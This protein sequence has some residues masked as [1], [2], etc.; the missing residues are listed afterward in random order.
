MKIEGFTIVD[1]KEILNLDRKSLYVAS[2]EV[3]DLAKA[4]ESSLDDICDGS[5]IAKLPKMLQIGYKSRFEKSAKNISAKIKSNASDKITKESGEIVIVQVARECLCEKFNHIAIPLAELFHSKESGNASF[6]FHSESEKSLI[7]FGEGKYRSKGNSYNL[8][9][10]QIQDFF[11]KNKH[12]DDAVHLAN[13]VT[14]NANK[15]FAQ[16]EQAF[17]AVF[18]INGKNMEK[19]L[20]NAMKSNFVRLVNSHS[21]LYLIGVKI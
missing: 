4:V 9:L 21:E 19:I 16:S 17:A 11:A 12:H 2:I 10:K 3:T 1:S 6:D 13:F 8:A 18:S 7:V 14:K 20:D 15:S 5:W